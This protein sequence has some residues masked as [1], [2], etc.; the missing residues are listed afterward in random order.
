MKNYESVKILS[1]FLNV[2]SP[3]TNLNRLFKTFWRWFWF[4]NLTSFHETVKLRSIFTSLKNEE[5]RESWT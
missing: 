3:C 2:K 4:S 1:N 5:T